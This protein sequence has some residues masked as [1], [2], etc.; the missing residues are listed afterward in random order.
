MCSLS[1]SLTLT[2]SLSSLT[3]RASA[4]SISRHLFASAPRSLLIPLSF[5]L[6]NIDFLSK[7]RKYRESIELR[8]AH[9]RLSNPVVCSALCGG[10]NERGEETEGRTNVRGIFAIAEHRGI[11]CIIATVIRTQSSTRDI[12]TYSAIIVLKIITSKQIM[13]QKLTRS[14]ILVRFVFTSLKNRGNFSV[15]KTKW[16][17]TSRIHFNFAYLTAMGVA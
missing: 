10:P 9:S 7:A 17:N 14:K 6:F 12:F 15:H 1:L 16:Y 11:V 3:L 4:I 5:W 2:H 8:V 13:Q